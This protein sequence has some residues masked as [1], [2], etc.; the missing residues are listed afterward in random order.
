MPIVVI[1]TE[2]LGFGLIAGLAAFAPKCVKRDQDKDPKCGQQ[3]HVQVAHN[4][5]QAD[6][7]EKNHQHRCKAAQR[8]NDSADDADF[9]Q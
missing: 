6:K 1:I 7:A 5:R 9:Q 8:G 3:D 4:R 2:F